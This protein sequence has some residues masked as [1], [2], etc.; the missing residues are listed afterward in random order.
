MPNFISLVDLL[1]LIPEL[2]LFLT[3]VVAMLADLFVPSNRRNDVLVSVSLG[4]IVLTMLAELQ[5]YGAGYT[6]VPANR[7]DDHPTL[8]ALYHRERDELR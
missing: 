4:G 5:L 7:T 1:P 2:I 8:T 6:G 3:L